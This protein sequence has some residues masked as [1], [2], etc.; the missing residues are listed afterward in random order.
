[1]FSTMAERNEATVTWTMGKMKMLVFLSACAV[2]FGIGI[3][4]AIAIGC[5]GAAGLRGKWMGMVS[6]F[7]DESSCFIS[8]RVIVA[9]IAR[10]LVSARN[11]VAR[12]AWDA[13]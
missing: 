5:R 8:E 3:A 11:A 9:A 6:R 13:I 10:G 4:R 7:L 2:A 12:S 1:M